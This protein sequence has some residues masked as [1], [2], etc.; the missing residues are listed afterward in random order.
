VV[1][2]NVVIQIVIQRAAA[3]QLVTQ[4]VNTKVT[5]ITSGITVTTVTKL[6]L[7]CDTN[8]YIT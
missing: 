5:M 6:R 1:L 3:A 4:W 8:R 7:G 2:S